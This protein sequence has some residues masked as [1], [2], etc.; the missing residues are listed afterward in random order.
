MEE[1]KRKL[2]IHL[3]VFLLFT[4][5]FVILPNLCIS[6]EDPAK[7]PSK[8]I[9]MIVPWTPGGGSDLAARKFGDGVSKILGQP[10]III[11]KGGGGGVIGL[12]ALAKAD[13]DGYIFGTVTHSPIVPIPHQRSVPYNT[14]ED[15][16]FIMQYCE[17]MAPF[18][19]L[20]D[21]PWKTFKEFMEDARKNPGKLTFAT[22]GPLSMYHIFMEQVAMQ[23]K[24]RIT[25]I[26]VSGDAE[27]VSQ[28]LGGH[29]DASMSSPLIPHILAKKVRALAVM[30][31]K[32]LDVIPDVP[33]FSEL[34]YKIDYA[35]FA[36]F[37]APKGVDP[38]IIKKLGDAF[39]KVWDD[40][41]NKEFLATSGMAPVYKNSEAF[42][43]MV[44]NDFDRMGIALKKLTD[45]K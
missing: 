31:E 29:V 9:T 19:V 37:I 40:P 14:K 16:S 18:C 17:Y 6:A 26:P 12:T 34:G 5:L 11:N 8:Q 21:S 32:R 20:T 33:T 25:H 44:F 1:Q 22:P 39:K 2:Q 10:I 7:F 41:S 3:T 45:I 15:F 30:N 28:H 23:E 24:V 43:A 38:R 13:P 42:K 4:T 27:M 36:G 35:N